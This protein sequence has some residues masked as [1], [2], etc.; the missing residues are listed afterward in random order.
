M[1][2]SPVAVILF[3]IC[4]VLVAQQPL[5]AP[6]APAAKRDPTPLRITYCVRGSWMRFDGL[7][8]EATTAGR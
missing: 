3:A 2:V 4:P 7:W 1:Q 6:Q 8:I 5:P